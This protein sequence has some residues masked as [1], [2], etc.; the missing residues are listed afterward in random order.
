MG[1]KRARTVSSHERL[2]TVLMLWICFTTAVNHYSQ[3]TRIV[4]LL[5]LNLFM[6]SIIFYNIDGTSVLEKH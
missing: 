5:M 4:V 2:E 6:F 3:E 1:H